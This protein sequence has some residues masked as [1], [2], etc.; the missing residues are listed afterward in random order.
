MGRGKFLD[1]VVCGPDMSGTSTQIEG[2]I[3]FFQNDGKTVK[4]LRGTEIDALF[5]TEKFQDEIINHWGA[6]YQ[7]L[8]EF[9]FRVKNDISA[10]VSRE[11]VQKSYKLLSG[12]GTNQDLRVA[13]MVKNKVTTYINPN[14]A[15]VWILEEPTKRGSGQVNR[16]IEQ[17]R[18]EFGDELNPKAAAESHSV[19][20]TDEFLRF[21][22]PLRENNKIIVRSR[23]E[24]SACYQVYDKDYLSKG[25][26]EEY[27][28]QLEGHKIAFANSP[29]NLFVVCGPENWKEK[30]YLEFRKSR[31]NGRDLDDH[32][33]K[34][35]YQLLVNKR[36]ATDWLENLYKKA[37]KKYG[38]EIPEITRF[39]IYASREEINQQMA[40]K[41]S[42]LLEKRIK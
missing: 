8:N 16:V 3:N 9:L 38:S 1:I 14:S 27:Y 7:N 19:Y 31:S 25:V 4:D 12:G 40:N 42:F 35:Q 20:R 28:L 34:T 41:I 18:S 32:E 5:H 36:Y 10:S 15:D 21:R 23:S 39:D 29:T 22:K 13:S 11:F 33:K 2:I 26:S 30:D 24:E 37:C 6:N 17:N